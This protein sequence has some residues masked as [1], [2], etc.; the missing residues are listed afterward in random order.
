MTKGTPQ[1]LAQAISQGA[2]ETEAQVLDF[3]RQRFGAA[4]LMHPEA[5]SVL[6]EL[7]AKIEKEGER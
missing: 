2:D 6:R 1:S 3:L 4:M 7:L 5:E